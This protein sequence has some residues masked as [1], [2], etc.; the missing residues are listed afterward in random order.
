[1]NEALTEHLAIA[2]GGYALAA[3]IGWWRAPE[4][5]SR[6]FDGLRDSSTAAFMTGLVCY[7]LG[8]FLLVL[9]HRVDD[10]LAIVVTL[11]AV[12]AVIEGLGFLI[13][14]GTFVALAQR[15]GLAGS[16]RVWAAVYAVFG[17]VLIGAGLVRL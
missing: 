16:W 12:G 10:W 5:F 6:M 9:H 17:I 8:A 1:M 2:I 4:R 7:F 14:S 11:F 13:G 15:I 3:A